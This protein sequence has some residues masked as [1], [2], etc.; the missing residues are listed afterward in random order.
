MV[1]YGYSIS[2]DL[3]DGVLA[4]TVVV[5]VP[6]VLWVAFFQLHQKREDRSVYNSIRQ[7]HIQI[8]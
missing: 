6:P 1:F 7:Q 8:G 5:S 3:M 4:E 2:Y